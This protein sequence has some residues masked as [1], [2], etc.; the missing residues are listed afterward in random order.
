VP[1]FKPPFAHSD[2]HS[3]SL[4]TGGLLCGAFLAAHVLLG[5]ILID[6]PAELADDPVVTS[7]GEG[8]AG[9][10]A[11]GGGSISSGQGG[12]AG[13]CTTASD[14]PQVECRI[15]ACENGTCTSSNEPA[16]TVLADQTAAD[17]QRRECDGAGNVVSVDD[18]AD[19]LD[20]GQEC[21]IDVCTSGQPEH[22]PKLGLTPCT[23]GT[24]D[25]FGN[26]VECS[27]PSECPGT[28]DYCQQ[29][30]CINFKCGLVFEAANT[31]LPPAEQVAG[32]C[33]TKMC[34]GSG[35][36]VE[37]VDDADTPM[38]GLQCT[39]DV[40]SNGVPSNP[41]ETDG[42]L[43][44]QD[45]GKLCYQGACVECAVDNDCNAATC[46]SKCVWPPPA[47]TATSTVPR[48][49]PT[50]VAPTAAH[51]TSARAAKSAATASRACAP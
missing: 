15:A 30:T 45:G 44:T 37:M 48:P 3:S 41:M 38:D 11:G 10:G 5:C 19:L 14:C 27:A 8:A 1:T 43:C 23:G 22:V 13:S 49:T 36:V 47:S 35:G 29:R 28:D 32:D 33:N 40:C 6:N 17:C 42:T 25:D 4:R 2:I 51:A 21:T 7:S 39:A 34:D 16:G 50:A 26:C 12:G 9:G 31:T 46:A 24:C 18:D 20:D